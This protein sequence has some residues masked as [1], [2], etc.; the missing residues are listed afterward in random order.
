VGERACGLPSAPA[1]RHLHEYLTVLGALLREGTVRF[2]GEEYRAA[3]DLG[4]PVD[5]PVPVLAAALA[6]KSLRSAGELADGTVLWMAN[7][8]A[9]E[10]LIAP[11]LREAARSAGRP[12]PRIVAG[13]PGAGDRGV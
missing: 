5:P 9:I 3:S 8:D 7:R 11:T 4:V 1:A 2:S 13:L 10:G 12:D 6:P